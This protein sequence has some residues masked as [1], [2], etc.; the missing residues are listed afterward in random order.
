M[1]DYCM[2]QQRS[3]SRL[4]Q[5]S[6]ISTAFAAVAV[7]PEV[8]S[9]LL[10][11]D[12]ALDAPRYVIDLDGGSPLRCCL[13][14]SLPGDRLALVAYAPLRRWAQDHGVDV[15]PYDEVGPIFLHAEGCLGREET[16]FPEWL[17]GSPRVIRAYSASGAIMGGTLV[18][19]HG[20]FEAAI[21]ELLSNPEVAVVHARALLFGCFTFEVRRVQGAT[22]S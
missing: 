7:A 20:G 13:Q 19:A 11:T 10:E 22:A 3:I 15:G 4:S 1:S 6:T 18:E 14:P 9:A 17:R 8:V 16:N 21:G 12:D 2:R 5:M